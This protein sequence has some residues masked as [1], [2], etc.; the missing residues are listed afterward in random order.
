MALLLSAY[1]TWGYRLLLRPQSQLS[2]LEQ[3]VTWPLTCSA[4]ITHAYSQVCEFGDSLYGVSGVLH[5][6]M[7]AYAKLH[8]LSSQ[9]VQ[10][11]S[12]QQ[13]KTSCITSLPMLPALP[14]I[15]HMQADDNHT[16]SE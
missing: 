7:I 11:R 15:D 12:Q 14:L 8:L 13:H 16:N 10:Q 6:S 5:A 3:S 2:L 9:T 4:P 1:V